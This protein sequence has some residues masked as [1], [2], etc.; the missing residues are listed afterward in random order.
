MTP[1]VIG[2]GHPFRRDDAIGPLVAERVAAATGAELLV[3]HGEGSDLMERWQGRARVVVVDATA[4]GAAPGTVRVWD[5]ATPLPAQL[6]PKGSHLF[7]LAEGIE[8]ARL[9]GRLPAAMIVVGVEG[10][11]FSAGE[12]LSPAVAAAVDEAVRVAVAAAG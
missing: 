4:S 6:F 2:I 5:A 3:H 9:L 11:D 12:G 10:Q 1:L 7:G 8:M